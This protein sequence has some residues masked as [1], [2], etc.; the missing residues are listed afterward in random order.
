[1]ISTRAF[2]AAALAALLSFAPAMAEENLVKPEATPAPAAGPTKNAAEG[3]CGDALGTVAELKQRYTTK[4]GLKEVD[5]SGD[6]TTYSDDP[7]NA[8]VMYN[9][10]N[11]TAPAHPAAVCRKLVR[12][13][14]SMVLKFQVV[15]EGGPNACEK[16]R[17]DFNVLIARMQAE[18]DNQINAGKGK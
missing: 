16:L 13:G 11:D 7:K 10:T 14:D 15:C 8:T 9:F 2:F 5:K 18:V 3:F 4:G 17:N 1:M 6:F 12:D